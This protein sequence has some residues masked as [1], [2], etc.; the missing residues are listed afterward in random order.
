MGVLQKL[1]L[2]IIEIIAVESV[3]IVFIIVMFLHH[4]FDAVRFMLLA[5]FNSNHVKCM[6]ILLAGFDTISSSG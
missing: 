2:R 4:V 5:F 3:I 6:Q 1:L